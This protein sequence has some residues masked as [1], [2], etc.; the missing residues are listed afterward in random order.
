[1]SHHTFMISQSLS[2][3]LISRRAVSNSCDTNF[4]EV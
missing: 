4:V 2:K 1:L 3:T